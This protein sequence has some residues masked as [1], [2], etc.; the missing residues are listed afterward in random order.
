MH[1]GSCFVGLVLALAALQ[2]AHA[3]LYGFVDNQG[4]VHLANRRVDV[5]YQPLRKPLHAAVPDNTATIPPAGTATAPGRSA[6]L[7]LAFVRTRRY[8]DLIAQTADEYRLDRHL[9]HSIIAVESGFNPA[10]VS[11][12][13]AIGLMQVMPQ[14]GRR[15]GID[16]LTDPRQNLAAGARYLRALYSQFNANLPLVIAAY[17]AGEGAVQKYRNT[18]PPYTETQDYVARVLATYQRR[19]RAADGTEA[20]APLAQAGG[21]PFVTARRTVRHPGARSVLILR[22]TQTAT[23]ETW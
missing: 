7:P 6:P 9:L 17:N 2:P 10:A 14:T 13:G 20:S 5:R 4:V 19:L 8:D 16:N 1:A 12:K 21:S 15:F 18:V 22:G 11:P 23:T 3:E